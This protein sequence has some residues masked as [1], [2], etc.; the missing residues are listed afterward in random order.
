MGR[1]GL[2]TIIH[3][4]K[5]KFIFK[6]TSIC[7]FNSSKAMDSKTWPFKMYITTSINEQQNEDEEDH[8]TFED[9][10][11]AWGEQSL[12]HNFYI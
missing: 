6:A 11:Q 12:L 1:L 9:H 10:N 3:K 2:R 5:I 4:K 8:T 7:P